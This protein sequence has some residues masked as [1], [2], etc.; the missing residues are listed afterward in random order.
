MKRLSW[1]LLAVFCAAMV[2]VQPVDFAKAKAH[3]C[4]PAGG[5]GMPCCP[6]PSPAS[7]PSGRQQSSLVA[8]VPVSR[9]VQIARI[10]AE[11]LYAVL[12]KPASVRRLVSASAEAAPV[13]MM[14]LFKAHCSFLI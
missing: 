9:R 3:S 1:L 2:Q 8:S 6:S 7:S 13:A 11:K 12:V 5:C 10:L 14:P 4:C